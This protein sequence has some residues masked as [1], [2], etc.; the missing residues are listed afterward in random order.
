MELLTSDDVE[1]ISAVTDSLRL[2][3]DWVVVP[4]DTVTEGLEVQQPDGK[5]VIH[6]PGKER[7]EAWLLGL[8]DRLQALNLG[9]VPRPEEQDPKASLTGPFEFKAMG[10]RRYLGSRGIL[11]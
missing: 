2:H 9:M 7:F 1:R 4:L 8:R 3:R 5:I 6:A 11:N 10:T